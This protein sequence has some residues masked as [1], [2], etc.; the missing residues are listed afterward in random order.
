MRINNLMRGS[1]LS[2]RQLRIRLNHGHAI[3][4]AV[5]HYEKRRPRPPF[6]L[7]EAIWSIEA[8]SYAHGRR[9][10]NGERRYNGYHDGYHRCIPIRFFVRQLRD[11]QHG[12]DCTA[13]G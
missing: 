2:L 12:D 1:L 7:I 5:K 3:T 6:L 10:H 9:S 13:V 11:G 4:F 8:L